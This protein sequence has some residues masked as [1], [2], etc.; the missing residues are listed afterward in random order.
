MAKHRW[1]QTAQIRCVFPRPTNQQAWDA[2]FQS[3]VAG[4]MIEIKPGVR[5]I[6]RREFVELLRGW[7]LNRTG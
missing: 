6:E 2:E 3:Q 5:I 1:I 7:A 4:L